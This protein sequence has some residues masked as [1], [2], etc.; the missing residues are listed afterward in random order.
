MLD[1]KQRQAL[2]WHWSREAAETINLFDGR[3]GCCDIGKHTVERKRRRIDG[4]GI[5][6]MHGDVDARPALRLFA[7]SRHADGSASC[8]VTVWVETVEDS[9]PFHKFVVVV[10]VV[11][12]GRLR[13]EATRI[14]NEV[15]GGRSVTEDLE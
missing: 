13:R 15:L 2:Q 4:G 8:E 1:G 3:D 9:G 12:D 10:V 7:L 14:G 6:R 11:F 5:G